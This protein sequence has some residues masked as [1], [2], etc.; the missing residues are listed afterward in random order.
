MQ[1]T[2]YITLQKKRLMLGEMIQHYG[3]ESFIHFVVFL[4]R[5]RD[6]ILAVQGPMAV[7]ADQPAKVKAS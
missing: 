6:Q 5:N 2:Y 7:Q 3:E 4:Y 1:E